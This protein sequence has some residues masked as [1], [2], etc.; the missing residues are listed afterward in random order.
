MKRLG[1]V[2]FL[3]LFLLAACKKKSMPE[4]VSTGTDDAPEMAAPD[5]FRF[6]LE[7]ENFKDIQAPL[8]VETLPNASGGKAVFIPWDAGKCAGTCKTKDEKVA[9]AT[10]SCWTEIDVPQ[11]GAAFFWLRA[12]WSGGCSN[13]VLLKAP[14]VPPVIVGEDGTY[15]HW[16]WVRGPRL[17]WKK[18]KKKIILQRREN[19]V[20]L[21]QILITS[22]AEYVPVGIEH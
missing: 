4:A 20:A 2:C 10:D 9:C 16:H 11:D 22:D 19:D 18:G 1:F 14:G 17:E 6:L 3:L 13:S 21:D 15:R 5:G 8:R 12:K 7:V